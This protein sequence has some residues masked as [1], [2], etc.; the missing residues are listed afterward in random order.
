MAAKVGVD[1]V[2]L[3]HLNGGIG[4][5]LFYLLDEIIS[6]RSDLSFY[7]YTTSEKGDSDHFRKYPNVT[8][9]AISPFPFSHSLWGQTSL[10]YALYRDGIDIFW[11]ST[12]SIPLIK[13]RQMKTLLTI[14]D[15][16]YLLYPQTVSTLKCLYLKLFSRQMLQ[17]ADALAPI[18]QGTADKLQLYYGVGPGEIVTPPL[19]TTIVRQDPT[20]TAAFLERKGLKF[21]DY[22]L[23]VGTLEPR[24][25]FSFLIR[26]Y[27]NLL[28]T[29][30]LLPLVLIGGGG[31]KNEEMIKELNDAQERYPQQ[32]FILG[33]IKDEELSYYLSGAHAYLCL[34]LYEGYGMPIAEA[35]VCGTQVVCFD[36]P[37][38]REAAENDALF[39]RND[40]LEIE[41]ERIFLRK[42]NLKNQNFCA[43]TNY[44]SNKEIAQ[45]VVTILDN[46][47]IEK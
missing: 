38:M 5:Y 27:L 25:N 3:L 36:F 16:A 39:L 44:L 40:G 32:I 2:P 28:K 23:T 34:S 17:R 41:L 37:E 4:Y 20:T 43:P 7:L 21:K 12:Q 47:R 10:A 24:K 19:K 33:S 29:R 14:Y 42:G 35:R 45:K 46:L 6:A 8:I 22:L 13:R 26:S 9:R 18:S 1:A 15:F 11:G 31:W 30:E